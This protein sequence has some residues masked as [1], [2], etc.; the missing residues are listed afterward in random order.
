MLQWLIYELQA[1][2]ILDLPYRYE[3]DGAPT[4]HPLHDEKI[5]ND[6]QMLEHMTTLWFEQKSANAD[7]ATL[8]VLFD[9]LGIQSC[10]D[11]AKEVFLNDATARDE[12][13]KV[14]SKSDLI[15]LT[16]LDS[17]TSKDTLVENATAMDWSDVPFIDLVGTNKGSGS[18]SLKA[19][20]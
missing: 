1:T 19:Y 14:L 20:L 10:I 11:V 18:N 16:G 12:Y 2:M 15:E 4:Y 8:D 6:E 3:H 7:F 13:F 17:K 5:D 9:K